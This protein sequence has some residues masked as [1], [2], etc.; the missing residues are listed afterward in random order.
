MKEHELRYKLGVETHRIIKHTIV[1]SHPNHETVAD[2]TRSAISKQASELASIA[3]GSM[4][5]ERLFVLLSDIRGV[6]VELPSN[7]GKMLI[8]ENKFKKSLSVTISDT[9]ASDFG[10]LTD[11]PDICTSKAVR[12]CICKELFECANQSSVLD[13]WMY[14]AIVNT[15]FDIKSSLNQPVHDLHSTFAN[16]FV[17]QQR[18]MG[19]VIQEDLDAFEDFSESYQ[20]DFYETEAYKRL[21]EM[22][23]DHVLTTVE[24]TIEEYTDV[25]FQIDGDEEFLPNT[26]TR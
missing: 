15:W 4:I 18:S 17:E 3:G 6:E 13:E 22:Y 12:Y 23:G 1:P 14:K 24:N 25:T 2:F 9:A 10:G 8:K 7:P 5:S 16:R 11:N 20:N 19:Y 21:K 26:T